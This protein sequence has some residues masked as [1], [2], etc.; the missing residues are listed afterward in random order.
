[1]QAFFALGIVVKGRSFGARLVGIPV[2]S[3]NCG[4]TLNKLLNLCPCFLVKMGYGCCKALG[5]PPGVTCIA[6]TKA[7]LWT[8]SSLLPFPAG[9]GHQRD[10]FRSSFLCN[11]F[12][13]DKEFYLLYLMSLL[14]LPSTMSPPLPFF[15][16]IYGRKNWASHVDGKVRIKNHSYCIDHIVLTFWLSPFFF[17]TTWL[18]QQLT[19][20]EDGV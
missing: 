18:S 13:G 17:L 19:R 9:Q 5:Y 6:T 8:G 14:T 2:P 7:T 1:M 20:C 12:P 16:I 11:I 4:M 10:W 3:P 15:R